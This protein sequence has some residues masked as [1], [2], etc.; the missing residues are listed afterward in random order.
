M[1]KFLAI[2]CKDILYKNKYMIKYT[3]YTDNFIDEGSKISIFKVK[4]CKKN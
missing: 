4:T 1:L 3:K 2:K